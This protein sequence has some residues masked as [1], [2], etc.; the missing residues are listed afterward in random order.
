MRFYRAIDVILMAKIVA[1][2]KI[3]P[4]DIIISKDELQEAVRKALPENISL[5]KIDEEP[6]AFGLVALIAHV[7]LP[8]TG[9]ELEKVE[10]IIRKVKGVSTVETILVR[11]I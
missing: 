2:I 6:I 5:Y 4:E 9:D 3:F 11:R 7:I 1:S 8:E 10:E